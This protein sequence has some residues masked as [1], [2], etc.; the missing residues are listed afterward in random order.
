[1][2][3]FKRFNFLFAMPTFDADDL[4]GIR[5]N[6][7]VDEIERS[8]FEVVKARKLEDATIAV[9]TDAAIGCMVVDWGKKGLEGKTAALINLMRKR[10]LDFPIIL[11]IRRKRFE[12]V[13]VEVLDFIDGYVFLSEETPP[14]IAKN[15]ISRLKQYAETLKTP[16]FGALVDYAEEG[17]QLWTC[18]G[19]NGG[20][21]YS[22]SPIGRVFMEH[23]GEAVFRDDLD[24]SVLDLGD[25]LTHEGPALQAQKEAAQIFGAEKTYFV[26]N[27][28]STSNK[29]ALSAL[30]TDGDLVL[31]DR[32]NHKAALHGA[33]MIS[34]GVPIYVP[35]TRNPWGLIG[36]M[37]WDALDE[38]ALRE[39][40]RINPLVTDPEA[41][42]RPRPFRVAVVEQC[43]YDG[44]IY[45]AEMI[46]ARIGH[47]CD[48]IL[49]DEAWAGFMKFHPLYAGRFAMGL[50]ELGP[51]SPGII[52]TQSTHKQLASFSQASQIHMKDRHIRGQKRRVE[53]RR[54]NESFMQHASTSPFYPLFASLD[55]GAQ[56]M[57]GRSGEVLW[58]DTIRL[59]IELRKK[60][61]AV[62]RE[63]EEKETR[64]E[65]R[66]FFEPFV[67]ERV[68]IPDAA[69]EG[70]VHN[71][72]WESI[73]TDQLATNP[74][75]WQ[76]APDAAWH[77][78][79]GMEAG[80]TMTDPNKLTVLTPGFDRT[81]G[82]YAEHG[83][84]APV[85]AQ[86]LREN[87][88]VPEKNDLNSLLFLL[89]PGVEASKAGT[90][91]SGLV[92]FKKFHD[93]NA[94]LEDVIPEF[95]RR[96]PARYAGIRL[97]DLCGDMHRF[98]REA[99]VSELQTKQ[100]SAD[101]L[102]EIAMSPHD[103]ARCLVRNDVDYLPIDEIFGRVATT[104]F[105]VYP[106]GIA[107]IVPGERLTERSKPM[108]D[109]LRMFETCF[110]TFPGFDVEI[111]GIYRK[112]GANGRI[113][114]YT[115]VVSE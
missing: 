70:A 42:K 108:I 33:L 104:P 80:F 63:F 79:P 110:N 99:N 83:I 6:Q 27:G 113:R 26:L 49:F 57:K 90:L 24:N 115:Y 78:F 64:A 17:N 28:T 22:R 87:R 9:Q 44:T 37:N 85:V 13:P 62:R 12:D 30:V 76:L 97:R 36:P 25:L 59:G 51:D 14:F 93:D 2:D 100:F 48:Y 50:K 32:N 40:I 95:A 109:Y 7:I 11:L 55:V 45:S 72:P 35:T 3:Y 94:L 75:Y 10:G 56:M 107:T 82:G 23:L 84:P 101:H 43:T 19:H 68:A 92:A 74:A 15:L 5:L 71:V 105:V 81:T 61:R 88:I 114:L 66:W 67:P 20:V 52:A 91:I 58:D 86:F 46:I 31:F 16:F 106:P 69:S 1:M 96:R 98:F 60:M 38:D 34:G 103:A 4:E 41:W 21:F 102:P 54:F 39:R 111:Q 89:T 112:V 18:P 8:G 77:G 29:V 47:L 73:G 65:R 53:H